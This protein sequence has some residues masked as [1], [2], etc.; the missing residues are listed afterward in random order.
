MKARRDISTI[1]S[2]CNLQTSL[3]KLGS[4]DTNQKGIEEVKAY[5]IQYKRSDEKINYFLNCL[6]P[7][8]E[9]MLS[10]NHKKEFIR[11]YGIVAEILE[12]DCIPYLGK[13]FG[14][15]LKK[16]KESNTVLN[17]T[18]SQT[19][20]VIIHNT[21]H[22]LPDLP[23]S[24]SQ[25]TAIFKPLFEVFS[26]NN[27]VI[28]VGCGL[29]LTKIIQHSPIECLRFMLP[30]ISLR[31]I[32]ILGSSKAQA[33]IIESLISL[34]LSVEQEFARYTSALVPELM[35][36]INSEDSACRKQVID[37]LY[38]LAA[39]VPESVEAFASEI[40][41]ILNKVRTDKIKP[42]R[43]SAIEAV[44]IY[45][46]LIPDVP[47]RQIVEV[48]S[49]REEFKPKSIF[50]GPINANFFEAAKNRH[51]DSI[52]EAPDKGFQ[53]KEYG[54]PEPIAI[55][56]PRSVSPSFREAETSNIEKFNFEE[57]VHEE[58]EGSFKI[59]KIWRNCKELGVEFNEFREQTKSDLYQINQRLGALE[60]MISTVSQLFDAKIK[61]I[62][63][64][65]NIS[66][67]LKN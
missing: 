28:Q 14:A 9:H 63:C 64:N 60:E 24:C 25:L 22:T 30:K 55:E 26:S 16:L 7:T 8:N 66:K 11:I 47:V 36:C 13:I 27:K 45:K 19:Y 39:V 67:L 62:T 49:P 17:E 48:R 42:I 6:T 56:S 46:K 44:N 3:G 20:G 31:L 41:T 23:S 40:L 35:N 50:K 32:Q 43:D 34:I 10:Q 57:S 58:N 2:S 54:R 21:L 51:N 1:D 12:G 38:T 53:Y 59:E 33:Q 37:A 65:P 5:I 15:L 52:V 4:L 18:I 61:Q 29:C